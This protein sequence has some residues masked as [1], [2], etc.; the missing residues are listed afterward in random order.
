[1]RHELFQGEHSFCLVDLKPNPS[2]EY[3]TNDADALAYFQR[4]FESGIELGRNRYHLFGSSN[5]QLQEHS[6]W[7]IKASTLDEIDQKRSQLG[8]LSRIDNLGTY[9]ARLGLWFS[10]TSPTGVSEYEY[11]SKKLFCFLF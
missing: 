1:M 6:F 8:E 5:S 4:T 9:A 2:E 10:T 11:F 3:L 7:F